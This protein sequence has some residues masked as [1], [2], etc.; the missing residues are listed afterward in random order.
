MLSL[1]SSAGGRGLWC[2]RSAVYGA[3]HCRVG[4]RGQGV[5]PRGRREGQETKG[6]RRYVTEQL[7]NLDDICL[8]SPLNGNSAKTHF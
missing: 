1:L 8:G 2:S 3:V 4:W 6:Q 7:P 5:D